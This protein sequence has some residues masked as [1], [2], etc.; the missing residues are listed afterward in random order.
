[1]SVRYVLTLLGVAA[2]I[3]LFSLGALSLQPRS[4]VSLIYPATGLGAA[5][6]WGFG[7]RWWPA[8]FLAQFALSLYATKSLTVALLVAFIELLVILLFAWLVAR[9]RVSPDLERLRDLAVF[10]G[11]SLIAPIAGGIA[12]GIGE[13]YFEAQPPNQI[14]SDALSFWLSDVVSLLIFVPLILGWRRWPFTSAAAFR[15]WL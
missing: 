3:T 12:S 1:M 4:D 11:A 6:L 15:K 7:S 10:V 14:L 5:L 2:A 13:I 8:A 9:L